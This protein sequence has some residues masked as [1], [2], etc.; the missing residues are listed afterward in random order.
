MLSYAFPPLPHDLPAKL[1]FFED[2][3]D[4]STPFREFYQ[5]ILVEKTLTK[6]KKAGQWKWYERDG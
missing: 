2:K 1:H 6:S 5:I 4:D 3:K